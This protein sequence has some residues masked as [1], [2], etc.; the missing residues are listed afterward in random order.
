MSYGQSRVFSQF[1]EMLRHFLKE[2]HNAGTSGQRDKPKSWCKCRRR[3]IKGNVKK[4]IITCVILWNWR[5]SLLLLNGT[6]CRL[7]VV[8]VTYTCRALLIIRSLCPLVILTSKVSFKFALINSR[9]V[10]YSIALYSVGKETKRA[11]ADMAPVSLNPMSDHVLFS[12]QILIIKLNLPD[13]L[14]YYQTGK[15]W[16]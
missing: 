13:K 4:A 8:Q 16:Q 5:G 3:G 11:K 6:V 14:V 7:H 10:F 15:T 9:R 1:I 2:F 12:R